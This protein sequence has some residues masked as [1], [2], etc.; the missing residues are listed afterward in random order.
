MI[1]RKKI[2][3]I[4]EI[5]TSLDLTLAGDIVD[6]IDENDGF[7]IFI[8]ASVNKDGSHSPN[9]LQLKLAKKSLEK[10]N[11]NASF[12]ISNNNNWN[13]DKTIKQ[14]LFINY[15]DSIRNSFSSEHHNEVDIWI[16]PKTDLEESQYN[17]IETELRSFFKQISPLTANISFTKKHNLPSLIA[18]LRIIKVGSPITFEHILQAIVSK[19]YEKP[20]NAW[21]KH[22][23]DKLRKSG[24]ISWRQP[25]FYYM[26]LLGLN[27]LGTE[28]NRRSGDIARALEL[29]QRSRYR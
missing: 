4:E 17:R 8:Q 5:L 1:D 9:R 28:K 14:F 6:K 22:S 10:Q 20:N 18:V 21:L 19:N 7:I 26:T 16:E 23:L 27:N 29:A 11:I 25:G 12:V 15:E 13:I 3:S 2:E 24:F